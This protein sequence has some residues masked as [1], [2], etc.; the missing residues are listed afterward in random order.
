MSK[1]FNYNKQYTPNPEKKYEPVNL[2]EDPIEEEK[3]EAC[4]IDIPEEFYEVS[5]NIP[6]NFRSY[7]KPDA[8]VRLVLEPGTK[9]KMIQDLGE[10]CE[11]Q[12]NQA[13]GFVMKQYIK[14][15]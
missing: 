11:V 9:L 10:W 3:C 5:S 13:V 8:E 2:N 15:V 7:P 14:K 1:K 12:Y 6:L 4:R